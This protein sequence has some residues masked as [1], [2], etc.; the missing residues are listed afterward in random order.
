MVLGVDIIDEKKYL[1]EGP[2]SGW[3]LWYRDMGGTLSHIVSHVCLGGTL[4]GHSLHA[5]L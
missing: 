1:Q 3:A 2:E 4:M 5:L